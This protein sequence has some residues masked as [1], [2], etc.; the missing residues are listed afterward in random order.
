LNLNG[1]SALT[2]VGQLSLQQN[3]SLEDLQG[4]EQLQSISALHISSN[5]NLSSCSGLGSIRLGRLVLE[6]NPAL[7]SCAGTD[8]FLS[9][10]FIRA[11]IFGNPL[12]TTVPAFQS[13]QPFGALIIRVNDS[14]QM[15]S[16]GSFSGYQNIELEIFNSIFSGPLFQPMDAVTLS[17]YL[18]S[19]TI[20]DL[21]GAA[22]TAV[23]VASLNFSNSSIATASAFPALQELAGLEY[24]AVDGLQDLSFLANV[25]RS[26][27]IQIVDNFFPP[28][29]T[30]RSLNGL[31]QLTR[32]FGSLR[33]TG[34][35]SLSSLAGLGSL[36]L[37]ESDLTIANNL[38]LPTCAANALVTQVQNDF[39][40]GGTISISNNNTTAVCCASGFHDNGQGSC[41][42]EG[43]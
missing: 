24:A 36:G 42:A 31:D 22:A 18:N 14:P 29:T 16:L 26:G 34:V 27:S 38:N 6:N 28:R 13:A 39:G 2:S 12:L 3:N 40:L 15:L 41:V 21:N 7:G 25:T 4:L 8:A 5:R 10:G 23:R 17:L 20:A 1:F 19:S 11:D 33:I 37:I 35:R 43:Q 30:L 32:I 9:D